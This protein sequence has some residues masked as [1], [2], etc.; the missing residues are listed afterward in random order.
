[1]GSTRWFDYFVINDFDDILQRALALPAEDRAI[2]ADYLLAS[3]DGPNQ[4]EI[5]A[6]WAEEAERRIREID[7]GK[8]DLIDGELVMARLRARFKS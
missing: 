4:K 1:L 6:A 2:L 3:L 5:D 7:E 8:V